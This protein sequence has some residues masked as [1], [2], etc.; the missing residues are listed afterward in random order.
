MNEAPD[1]E[2]L[3]QLIDVLNKNDYLHTARFPALQRPLWMLV[4]EP[5]VLSRYI[6]GKTSSFTKTAFPSLYGNRWFKDHED[7]KILYRLFYLNHQVRINS[8]NRIVGEKLLSG[9]VASEIVKDSTGFAKSVYRLTPWR[10]SI[11][12]C[13]PDQGAHRTIEYY[14]YVGYDSVILADF[15]RKTMLTREY[16]RG[17]DLCAGTAFQGHNIRKKCRSVLAAEYNPRAVDFARATLYA[18]N[19]DDSFKVV[20]SDLWE[21]VS[22]SFDIIVSNPPYYPVSECFRNSSIL[23][24]F[25]GADHGMEK[26]LIIFDGFGQYL[27]TGGSG[28]LL[29]ASPVIAGIDTL[30]GKLEPIAEKHGL[31]TILIPW[32]YTNIKLEPEY[33]VKHGIDYLIHYIIYTRKTGNGAVNTAGYPFFVKFLEKLQIAIQKRLPSWSER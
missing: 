4:L 12:L 25:G 33:Q 14:V 22:G 5:N 28:A 32:K 20:Q 6:Q 26:P 9:L 29:A 10:N 1:R 11:F 21:N 18:N 16:S 23:D 15:V 24:V 2:V 13:D 8:L 27:E 3:K 17:L 7:A 19:M 31:E 30:I